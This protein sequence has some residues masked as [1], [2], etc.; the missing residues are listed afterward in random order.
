MR[1]SI[2][3]LDRSP[4]LKAKNSCRHARKKKNFLQFL[5]SKTLHSGL[6]FLPLIVHTSLCTEFT[7]VVT[8]LSEAT[9]SRHHVSHR[10]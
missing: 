10:C 8:H 3:T 1:M 7:A 5:L 6:S 2:T 9:Y 4:P